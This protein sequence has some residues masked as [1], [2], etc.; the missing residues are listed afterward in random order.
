MKEAVKARNVCL[1]VW[2]VQVSDELRNE[3]NPL[4]TSAPFSVWVNSLGK[5]YDGSWKQNSD[6]VLGCFLSAF[7]FQVHFI[8]KSSFFS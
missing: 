4:L 6:S 1:E 7:L 3:I 8:I 5:K 2:R